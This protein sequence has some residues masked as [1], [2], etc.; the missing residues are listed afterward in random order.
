MTNEKQKEMIKKILEATIDDTPSK[1]LD[2]YREVAVEY[3]NMINKVIT[4]MNP[5]T[6]PIAAAAL[7]VMKE[8][9]MKEM[10]SE[11]E[12]TVKSI[13]MLLK[14]SIRSEKVPYHK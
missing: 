1:S 10:N 3:L 12:S 2:G 11:V 8:I 5:F 4:P 14:V 9:V 13:E 7:G 6:A